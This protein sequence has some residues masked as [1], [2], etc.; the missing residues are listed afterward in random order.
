M[1][2]Q[3]IMTIPRGAGG[4][5]GDSILYNARGNNTDGTMTQKATTFEFDRIDTY[6]DGLL[7][8][9]DTLRAIIRLKGIGE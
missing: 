4:S 7:E 3:V 1:K 6:L 8:V 9:R 2:G 5:G